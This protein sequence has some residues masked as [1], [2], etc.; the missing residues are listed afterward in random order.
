MIIMVNR[1][2]KNK[3]VT[4]RPNWSFLIN[5]LLMFHSK[6]AGFKHVFINQTTRS[7]GGGRI[8]ATVETDIILYRKTGA[9]IRV[10]LAE[11]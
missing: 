6:G 11:Y 8:E 9:L 10:S 1:L 4:L 3:N 7:A 2:Y 5:V